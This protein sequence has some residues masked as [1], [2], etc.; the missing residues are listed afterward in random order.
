MRPPATARRTSSARKRCR[1]RSTSSLARPARAAPISPWIWKKRRTTSPRCAARSRCCSTAST[2]W[3]RPRRS[4]RRRWTRPRSSWRSGRRG[5]RPRDRVPPQESEPQAVAA[6]EPVLDLLDQRHQ[7]TAPELSLRMLLERQRGIDQVAGDE[8]RRL[9][10]QLVGQEPPVLLAAAEAVDE[11]VLA[12][13]LLAR[14]LAGDAVR[15]QLGTAE[16]GQDVGV[17]GFEIGVEPFLDPR[18]EVAQIVDELVGHFVEDV[19]LELLRLAV[20]DAVPASHGESFTVLPAVR[21]ERRRRPVE[22]RPGRARSPAAASRTRSRSPARGRG[23]PGATAARRNR[24]APDL[25]RTGCPRAA[26]RPAGTSGR[27]RHSPR[28]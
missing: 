19:V 13:H 6:Q 26:S 5:P 1:T 27:T 28:R 12:Q 15:V 18:R 14:Q 2:R 22:L 4:T 24:P 9:L 20:E 3:R 16:P 25:A 7:V 21:G 23:P 11:L 8:V 10:L 17:A